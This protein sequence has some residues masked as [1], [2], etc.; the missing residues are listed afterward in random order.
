MDG[1]VGENTQVLGGIAAVHNDAWLVMKVL[2]DQ[3]WY[4]GLVWFSVE[5]KAKDFKPCINEAFQDDW[6]DAV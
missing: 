4:M 3:N 1:S 2:G 6:A 5:W